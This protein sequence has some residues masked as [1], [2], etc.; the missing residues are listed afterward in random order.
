ML[1]KLALILLSSALLILTA[2]SGEDLSDMQRNAANPDFTI[3]TLVEGYPSLEYFWDNTDSTIVN[4]G[5][6][7][8][9]KNRS[10]EF[11]RFSEIQAD[12]MEN[13]PELLTALVAKGGEIL[14]ALLDEEEKYYYSP[15][16]DLFY[17]DRA[18][19][20][21]DGFYALLKRLGASE[22]DGLSSGLLK[23]VETMMSHSIDTED[24][25]EMNRLAYAALAHLEGM[26]RDDIIDA[27][28][29]LSK[30]LLRA[31]YPIYIDNDDPKIGDVIS[32]PDNIGSSSKN[33][34]IGNITRGIHTLLGTLAQIV[35]TDQELKDMLFDLL[36]EV[37]VL[38]GAKTDNGKDL[39]HVMK[40]MT[41]NIEK[42]FLPADAG[43]D[44]TNSTYRADYYVDNGSRYADADMKTTMREMMPAIQK[45][46]LGADKEGAV[47][48]EI[49]GKGVFVSA[50]KHLKAAGMDL[51]AIDI[52][53]SLTNMIKR[54][55][56]GNIRTSGSD[57]LT[58]LD[59]LLY[60]LMISNT[61]GFREYLSTG[62]NRDGDLNNAEK[63]ADEN[64][65]HIH[66]EPTGG[67]LTV[68]DSLFSMH[69]LIPSDQDL[70]NSWCSLE[71]DSY[72]LC[73]ES[74]VGNNV[75]RHKD[76]FDSDNAGSAHWFDLWPNYPANL[77]LSGNCIGDGG[78]P[79]GGAST[80]RINSYD[81]ADP[82]SHMP[83]SPS[84]IG[85]LNTGRWVVGW[86]ARSCWEGEGPY[87]Y[88]DPTAD[89]V[90]VEGE[91][92]SKYLRPDGSIYAYVNKVDPGDP[93]TW[94]YK[95][96][97]DASYDVDR[98]FDNER[99]DRFKSSWYSDYHLINNN[100]SYYSP[101]DMSG[102]SSL[103]AGRYQVNEMMQ[104][105]HY[106]ARECSS[107]EEAM[108]KN[109]QW[110]L[111]EKKFLYVMPMRIDKTVL[112]ASLRSAVYVRLEGNGILGVSNI[113]KSSSMTNTNMGNSWRRITGEWCT[114]N[115]F[116]ADQ[117]ADYISN[118]GA[119]RIIVD[120]KEA[121]LSLLFGAIKIN[122][123][124]TG[125]GNLM[126][127]GLWDEV[128]GSG[129]VLPDAVGANFGPME[130][131]VYLLPNSIPSHQAGADGAYWNQRSRLFPILLS[132]FGEMHKR[133]HY[134]VPSS[135]STFNDHENNRYPLKILTD[136]LI[137][138]LAKPMYYYQIGTAI[139]GDYDDNTRDFW[140]PRVATNSADYDFMQHDADD[141]ADRSDPEFTPKYV[142]TLASFAGENGSGDADGI[143]PLIN[144]SELLPKLFALI[145]KLSD[146]SF[147]D[148][149]EY[150]ASDMSTWG[151]RSKMA[152]ALEQVV[153]G[154]KTNKA[155]VYDRGY[156]TDEFFDRWQFK[157]NGI[158]DC[159]IDLEEIMND[160]FWED[161]NSDDDFD[162]GTDKQG[163]MAE[164]P[165][166]SRTIEDEIL[167]NNGKVVNATLEYDNVD[168]VQEIKVDSVS[169]DV[170]INSGLITGDDVEG[171]GRFI[172]STGDIYFT[173]KDEPEGNVTI[174][175][176]ALKN[177]D[178]YFEN[179]DDLGIY[180]EADSEYFIWEDLMNVAKAGLDSM[181]YDENLAGELKGALY[182]LGKLFAHYDGDD[183]VYQ[184][185]SGFDFLYTTLKED[186]PALQKLMLD[187]TGDNT[188][189]VTLLLREFMSADGLVQALIDSSVAMNITDAFEWREIMADLDALLDDPLLTETDSDLWPALVSMLEDMAGAI[190]AGNT[191][192]GDGSTEAIEQLYEDFGFQY[193]GN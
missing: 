76:S 134:E 112:G 130:R 44:E 15:F 127:I 60:T 17:T 5:L 53:D 81:A 56:S 138:A 120:M 58:A 108:V 93:T 33:L 128:L 177:W 150:D 52:R 183:W 142:R 7:K 123:K 185:E 18:S 182:T 175:Y 191:V 50:L 66:G 106:A 126:D 86:L 78:I 77:M 90:D 83:Y 158:R 131:M 26:D 2:C 38:Y 40:E 125:S 163:S 69:T 184:G 89:Q 156:I 79:N 62:E 160:M 35:S 157:D 162:I 30:L 54:D 12:I 101:E 181:T 74:A 171:Y 37:P 73:F 109:F 55:G 119:G 107:Q 154:I 136:V 8:A 61:V 118:P 147:D 161:V 65:S 165:D 188:E 59:H 84:G 132:L 164:E 144:K 22:A 121:T 63:D 6:S 11:I 155:P 186:L 192:S 43:E 48:P 124:A 153:T 92:Y 9:M 146:S 23:I 110:L 32:D 133:S 80:G 100:G 29:S 167:G 4:E 168:T 39:A 41:E 180:I 122:M 19:T 141:P 87:Y 148:P 67:V 113:R 173:L 31:D 140:R 68:N 1:K 25:S 114:A 71:L 70:L 190:E 117:S 103:N 64:W 82:I 72:S 151:I 28:K 179:F 94:V 159:D 46:M 49:D 14:D 42:Y 129:Y 169:I 152:Y 88:A 91:M 102:Q 172:A 176:T 99:D 10:E 174:S 97:V 36:D 166:A 104:P 21:Q 137:P 145:Q 189:A 24:A 85:E 3:F 95:Y 57:K 96:P 135:G 47:I 13:N 193:N 105:S 170:D 34:N 187:D 75:F 178:A 20:Y 115:G 143:L 51:S 45:L 16:V 116:N 98:D 139:S 149:P 27:S 111:Y